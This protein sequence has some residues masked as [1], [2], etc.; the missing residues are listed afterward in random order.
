MRAAD[1]EGETKASTLEITVTVKNVE[2]PGS[3]GLDRVQ[4]QTGVSL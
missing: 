2:E 4:P 3:I 1:A